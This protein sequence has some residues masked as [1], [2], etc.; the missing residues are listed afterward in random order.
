[1]LVEP[2]EL[3]PVRENTRIEAGHLF[4]AGDHGWGVR[5]ALVAGVQRQLGDAPLADR[6]FDICGGLP[7]RFIGRLKPVEDG[8]GAGCVAG[9]VARQARCTLRRRGDVGDGAAEHRER[10]GVGAVLVGE[11][12]DEGFLRG[13]KF[14]PA[15]PIACL[16][17]G[18]QGCDPLA[19]GGD[20]GVRRPFGRPRGRGGV[21]DRGV[22]LGPGVN[23]L[24]L[25][26]GGDRPADRKAQRQ[27][28]GNHGPRPH[29]GPP[30]PAAQAFGSITP[31]DRIPNERN[32]YRK[33]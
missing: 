32:N 19:Q 10:L 9:V 7:G 1:M 29:L 23:D 3:H 18:V 21:V 26:A 16:H 28:Q 6:L 11:L 20:P 5:L 2:I 17:L 22:N 33:R 30:Q 14:R 25:L 27:Q 24:G 12:G 31:F 15:A 4:V 13:R 8:Q